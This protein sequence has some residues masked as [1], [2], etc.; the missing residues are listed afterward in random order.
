MAPFGSLVL[1]ISLVVAVYAVCASL[2]GVRQ[3]RQRLVAS[4][5]HAAYGVAALMTLAS[6]VIVQAFVAH[7]YSSRSGQH[8]SDAT[9]PLI[10]KITA[11]WGGLDGSLLFWVFILSGFSAI[12]IYT[13]RERH[14]ELIPYVVAVCMSVCVF[15][16][17]MLI[18]VKNPFET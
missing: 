1:Y 3:R 8:Y 12:A 10:Y 16:I 6:A 14:R 7:D 9:M 11:Y 18:F 4:G 15:F 13:N 5:I 2:V 17:A